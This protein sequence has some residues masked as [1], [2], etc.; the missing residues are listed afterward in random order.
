ML[1]VVHTTRPST[2]NSQP[3]SRP[4]CFQRSIAALDDKGQQRRAWLR[5]VVLIVLAAVRLQS[6]TDAYTFARYGHHVRKL[7]ND[8]SAVC[9]LSYDR[10]DVRVDIPE[11]CIAVRLEK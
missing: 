2:Y 8:K 3:N 9:V 5:K 4:R 11:R 7:S 10:R 1:L 6:A